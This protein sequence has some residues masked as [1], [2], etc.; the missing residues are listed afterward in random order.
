MPAE[1]TE[2]PLGGLWI[3]LDL[4]GLRRPPTPTQSLTPAWNRA[5]MGPGLDPE[6]L[7]PYFQS[8]ILT[9]KE[10]TMWK[11]TDEPPPTTPT[12]NPPPA[13][14]PARNLGG[15]ARRGAAA[16]IGPSIRIQGDLSGEEDLIVEGQV[17]GKIELRQNGV[18]IGKSGRVRADVWGRTISVEGEVEGN[19]FADEQIVVRSSGRVQGNLTA[20]RVSLDDGA[21]FKGAIDMEPKAARTGAP[22]PAGRPAASATAPVQ[23]ELSE[24]PEPAAAKREVKGG[25]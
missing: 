7:I 5:T 13:P 3:Y 25:S 12:L 4:P 24:R 9:N 19:L 2:A 23:G 11:R 21:K 15:E 17:E 16:T 14:T 18:T 20:P 6:L 22:P 10:S 1:P 8:S